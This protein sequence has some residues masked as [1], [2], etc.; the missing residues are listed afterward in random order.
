MSQSGNQ[1]RLFL[2]CFVALVATAFGFAV[3]GA[4]LRDWE[5]QFGLTE[6]QKGILGGVGLFPFAISI[7]LLSL[8]VDRIGYGTTMTLAFVGHLASAVLTIFA[9][10]FQVLYIATFVYAL[11]NGAVEAVINPAVATIHRENK[12]H[13]LNILHAGWPG[14]LVL[15]GLLSIL[16]VTLVGTDGAAAV[17]EAGE[18]ATQGFRPWQWQMTVLLLPILAYGVILFGQSFPQ[19]ERVEAGVSFRAMLEE[20]GWASAYIVSFLIIMGISQMLKVFKLEE[21]LP[22]QA[23]AYALIPTVV[24]AFYIRSFGR[25]MFVFLMLIMFLLATTELGTDSWIQ[26]IIGSV[27]QSP[28]T[29]TWFLV[30]TSAIMFVLRFFAGPIVHRISPLGLLAVSAA[31]AAVGL[32]WLGNAGATLGM[33]LAAATLYAFGKTFFWPTTLG[34]VSEQYPK[35]GALLLNAISGVGMISIGTIGGPAIGTLQ[36]QTLAAAVANE[37]PEQYEIVKKPID[38]QFYTYEAIDAAKISTLPAV[39][40]ERIQQLQRDTKQHALAKIAVLPAIMCVCYLV[41]IAYF[42][43]KGGYQAE[44]LTGHAANDEK[45]TGGT[46]GPGEG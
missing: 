37:T 5:L 9:P 18:T 12:T 13:W 1:K 40:R 22:L 41:L 46:E 21:I 25:P 8:V 34:V 17:N 32:T 2:G 14:G 43:S 7:I 4:V 23:L 11:S 24:F 15:G 38:G 29:G 44:V 42:K 26:D 27:R 3:R 16:V 36:D 10:N 19:Q 31:I 35:G 28:T 33:L 6:E 39:D 20:F 45:F 30:Y